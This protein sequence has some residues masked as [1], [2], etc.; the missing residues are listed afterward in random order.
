MTHK[1]CA[2]VHKKPDGSLVVQSRW[3]ADMTYYWGADW[4]TEKCVD[5]NFERCFISGELRLRKA[6]DAAAAQKDLRP[7]GRTVMGT[8]HVEA[9]AEWAVQA[10]QTYRIDLYKGRKWLLSFRS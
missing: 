3:I 4:Y 9:T 8:G 6:G 10:G 5:K 2:S 7:I 1:V